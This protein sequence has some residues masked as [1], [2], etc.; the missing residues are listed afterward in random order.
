[1]RSPALLL[2]TVCCCSLPG[3]LGSSDA[4]TTE[5]PC[6]TLH[7][8]RKPPVLLRL[9]KWDK[10]VSDIAAAGEKTKVTV[11]V[12]LRGLEDELEAMGSPT[13][14]LLIGACDGTH[15]DLI[16]SIDEERNNTSLM[17]VEPVSHNADDVDK[18]IAGMEF[19]RWELVRGAV[20]SGCEKE[21]STR[22]FTQ[23]SKAYENDTS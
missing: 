23:I 21:G 5:W 11:E 12:L 4:S 14:V 7:T 10:Y 16:A 13:N 18:M 19:R 2:L 15:D 20:D 6:S 3:R 9:P 17:L 8:V 1:M 22:H